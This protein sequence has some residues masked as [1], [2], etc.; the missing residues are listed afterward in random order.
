MIARIF[1]KRHED[2]VARSDFVNVYFD[3]LTED[4]PGLSGGAVS[5][6]YGDALKRPLVASLVHIILSLR[7]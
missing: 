5:R 7:C 1:T 2:F 4:L 6:V 3:F